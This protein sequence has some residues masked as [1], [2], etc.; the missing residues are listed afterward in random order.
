MALVIVCELYKQT[1]LKLKLNWVAGLDG[2]N[3]L[4]NPKHYDDPN[5]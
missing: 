1:R 2:G 5:Y 4:L 3:N